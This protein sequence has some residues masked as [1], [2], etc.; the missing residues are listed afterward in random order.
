MTSLSSMTSL[1]NSTIDNKFANKNIFTPTNTIEYIGNVTKGEVLAEEISEKKVATS[2]CEFWPLYNLNVDGKDIGLIYINGTHILS[3]QSIIRAIKKLKKLKDKE[4]IVVVQYTVQYT[5]KTY[6]KKE[7]VDLFQTTFEKIQ[8]IL[9]KI[10]ELDDDFQ[11]DQGMARGSYENDERRF[12]NKIS[13][14]LEQYEKEKGLKGI[15]KRLFRL[16]EYNV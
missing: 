14:T 16:E 12:I 15:V 4:K 1:N 2:K 11:F 5:K 10:E 6:E 9:E 13:N 8:P 7:S 3:P